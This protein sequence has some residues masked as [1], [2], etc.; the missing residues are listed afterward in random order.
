[1]QAIQLGSLF[2][3]QFCY[4]SSLVSMR[5]LGL[6]GD[7]HAHIHHVMESSSFFSALRHAKSLS[8]N[9]L[10]FVECGLSDSEHMGKT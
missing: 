2:H 5:W 9:D 4:L 6:K 10:V 8:G 1:M 3:V 7:E